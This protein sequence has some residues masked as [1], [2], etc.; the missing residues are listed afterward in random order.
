MSSS[1][2]LTLLLSCFGVS[3]VIRLD[4]CEYIGRAESGRSKPMLC[5]AEDSTGRI[6]NVYVKYENFH[7]QLTKDHLVCELVANKFAQDLGLPVAQ[8]CLVRV[9]V[10]F[11]DALPARDD[12]IA[13][14]VALRDAPLFAFGSI[15]INPVRRWETSDLVHKSQLHDAYMLYL[16][17][18]LVENTDRG[19][20][21]PNL[22]VYGNSFKIIDFGHSFQ[23]C[24]QEVLFDGSPMPWQRH[25]IKNHFQG[26]LQ[27][28]MFSR[29]R[30]SDDMTLRHFKSSLQALNDDIIQSYLDIVPEEWDQNTACQIIEYLVQARQH[31]D[32]FINKVRGVLK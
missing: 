27:H 1:N 16:F 4:A 7:A 12:A 11:I 21:N 3:M 22:L 29:M 2:R 5:A 10:D 6:H 17:D 9:D 25:G 8:P 31:A 13:L 23:R 14:R 18:T 32:E 24:H 20:G 15:Q 19:H 26:N 28:I 30:E